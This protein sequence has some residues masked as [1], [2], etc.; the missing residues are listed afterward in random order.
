MFVLLLWSLLWVVFVGSLLSSVCG[1]V[2][3]RKR[4]AGGGGGCVGGGPATRVGVGVGRFKQRRTCIVERVAQA[5]APAL[6]DAQLEEFLRCFFGG[7]VGDRIEIAS[8]SERRT[9]GACGGREGET[10]G[11]PHNPPPPPQ[12]TTHLVSV[13]QELPDALRRRVRELDRLLAH[14]PLR[15]GRGGRAGVGDRLRQKREGATHARR[16]RDTNSLS[17]SF[18]PPLSFSFCCFFLVG[19]VCL[20]CMWVG[21]YAR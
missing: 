2:R 14:A 16:R 4:G 7:G 3:G 13:L 10:E 6:L 5:A 20:V 19:G 21:A 15:G 9:P 8:V 1:F 17:S 18:F 12:K 11:K